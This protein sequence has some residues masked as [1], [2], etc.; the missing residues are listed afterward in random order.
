MGPEEGCKQKPEDESASSSHFQAGKLKKATSQRPIISLRLDSGK[1]VKALVDTGAS[2]TLI[3]WEVAAE[4]FRMKGLPFALRKESRDIISV[5]GDCIQ[6]VGIADIKVDTGWIE[7]RVVKGLSHDL[8]LGWDQ[9]HRYGWGLSDNTASTTVIWGQHVYNVIKRKT[10]EVCKIDIPSSPYSDVLRQYSSVFGEPEVLLPANLPPLEIV[11]EGHPICQRPYRVA[12]NK[13]DVIDAELDKMLKLG[14]VRPSASEWASPVH[15]VPK[16]DGSTRFCVDYRK[17]NSVT[18]KD[19]YPLP[20]IREIFDQLTGAKVFTLMDLRSGFW[21]L[22]VQPNSIHKTAFT[23]HRGLY[24]FTR[25]PFGLCNAPSAYQRAMNQVLAQ[26]IGKSAMVFIDDIVIFS[27][28]EADHK[29][30]LAEVLNALKEAGLTVKQEKCTFGCSQID[31]LGYVV[32]GDGITAQPQKTTA[33]RNLPPPQDVPTL[34]SFLGMA[35]YYRQL[36]PHYAELA[37][38]L[39]QLT[40]KSVKWEWTAVHQNAFNHLRQALISPC[41]MAYP[42]V[43]DPY[44]LYTDASDYAIGGI[45]CQEDSQGVERPLQYIS[46]QL[47]VTQ[48]KWATVEK[49]SFAVIYCLKKLRPYLLGSE[50]VVYTDHKPLLSLFTKEMANTKIQRWAV[51]MSEYGAKV[52]YRPGPNNVRADMLSRIREPPEIA[53]LDATEEWVTIED[54]QKGQEPMT[55][56]IADNIDL[57][58]C[59]IQQRREFPEIAVEAGGADSTYILHEDLIYSVARPEKHAGC[60]PRL[61]LPQ[62]FR[63]D[64]IQRCHEE[65]GHQGV[66]KTLSRIQEHY[67]WPGMRAQVTEFLRKC[68]LCIVHQ[69]RPERPSMGE[70]PTAECPGQYVSLDLIG[71]MVPSAANSNRYILVCLDHYSGWAE[72]YPLRQKTNEAVWSYLRNDYLPRHGAPQVIITDNGSEFKGKPFAEWLKGHAIEHRTTTPYHPQSNGKIERLNRTLKAMLRKLVNGDRS[73]WEEKLGTALMA[74][75]TNVSSVTHFTPFFLH[76][77]RPPRVAVSRLVAGDPSHTIDNRLE[78]QEQVMREAAKHTE[79]SRHYNRER[80]K[81]RSNAGQIKVGDRVVLKAQEALTLTAKWDFGYIVTRVRGHVLSLLHPSTG[82]RTQVHRDKV[83]LISPDIAW[84]KVR[85]RPRRQQK[86]RSGQLA[87][88]VPQV[89]NNADNADNEEVDSEAGADENSGTPR[90][91]RKATEEP[92][93]ALP[94]TSKQARWDSEQMEVLEF[95]ASYFCC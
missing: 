90:L 69:A 52:K 84:D 58:E 82:Y 16:K 38:P 86:K 54:L 45:L 78:L 80:L 70:M 19:R 21:Q 39:H 9:L 59:F 37:E 15:L 95:V 35:G 67:V 57:D 94:S 93:A 48:R 25:M 76:H 47:D 73:N 11:T 51:L 13:R 75:R 20:V 46:A 12:L 44:I 28:N 1:S 56:V 64:V 79:Q 17:L 92:D 50:F 60:Y 32:S 87:P 61:L 89:D 8:I 88:D 49:E 27:K 6:V 66:L 68:G 5:S 22:P 30:H 14:I 24:E 2:L 41:V 55:P 23:C 31:L 3:K 62:T 74:Y 7:V 83:R 42:S 85:P 10:Q 65:S 40:R 81:K 29:K 18:I 91:K 43:N 4:Y 34:R 71:P 72:A 33:I 53:I 26:F 63:E 36:V 77:A